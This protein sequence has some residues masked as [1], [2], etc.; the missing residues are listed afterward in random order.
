MKLF[1]RLNKDQLLKLLIKP[2]QACFKLMRSQK[3]YMEDNY[4]FLNF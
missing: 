3:L 4:N 1:L 2:K